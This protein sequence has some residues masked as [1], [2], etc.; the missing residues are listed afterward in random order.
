MNKFKQGQQVEWIPE[1]KIGTVI[2]YF[3]ETTIKV[4]FGDN[5]K[6][7]VVHYKDLKPISLFESKLNVKLEFDKNSFHKELLQVLERNK[8]REKDYKHINFKICQ[9]YW[10]EIGLDIYY[11]ESFITDIKINK[12]IKVE[13]YKK[14]RI[15]KMRKLLIKIKGDINDGDY[16][17]KETTITNQETINEYIVEMN[18]LYSLGDMESYIS[19]IKEFYKEVAQ[20]NILKLFPRNRWGDICHTVKDIK[21]YEQLDNGDLKLIRKRK[22][23]YYYCEHCGYKS[24]RECFLTQY[25]DKE[26]DQFISLCKTCNEIDEEVLIEDGYIK[27]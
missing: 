24:F 4:M 9:L 20:E 1:N 8:I 6:T 11:D 10:N 12:F 15:N 17:T 23:K 27:M 25:Y 2:E 19:H 5:N 3:S 22:V 18:R 7:Y 14:E 21:M 13:L 26:T 16:I